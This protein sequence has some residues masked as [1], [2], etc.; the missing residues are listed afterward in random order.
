MFDRQAA[1]AG[2]DDP[3]DGSG[4][5][6]YT[7]ENTEPVPVQRAARTDYSTVETGQISLGDI[8]EALEASKQQAGERPRIPAEIWALNVATFLIAIGFSLVVPV[9][10]QYA[11]GFGVSAT[12]VTVVV[13]AFAAVRL[14]WAP[15]A[16]RLL[17]RVGE[18]RTYS[19]GLL[20]VALSSIAMAFAANYV[21]L[22]LFRGAGGIGSAMFTIAAASMM[23]KYSPPEIRGKISAIWS[24][25]FLIGNVTG[26]FFGGILGQWGMTV[27]FISYGVVLILA[28]IIVSIV[29][30]RSAR[31]RSGESEIPKPALTLRAV[32]PSRSYRASLAFALANGWSSMGIRIAVVPL[33]IGATISAEPFDAGLVVAVGAIGN[34]LALQWSGRASDRRGRRPLIIAGLIV[35]AIGVASLVWAAGSIE[36]VLLGMFVSGLGSGLSMPVSQAAMSDIV[37]RNHTGGRPLAVFQMT[38]DL[39]MILGPMIAGALID[40]A[41]FQWSFVVA[42]L[43][44]FVP[45]FAWLSAPDTIRRP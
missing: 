30:R 31:T 38:Q 15:A 12:L 43:V 34:M 10:P 14:L 9:L 11:K 4:R 5:V 16:G 29:V 3:Q 26:P 41:G 20:I 17:E 39:G 27:P 36:L 45:V 42:S 24:G 8:R 35:S 25:A 19:V 6:P 23:A 1:D 21:Q 44:L 22:L 18:R 2:G 32:W 33:F 13:S 40:L 28:A 37:G 7:A